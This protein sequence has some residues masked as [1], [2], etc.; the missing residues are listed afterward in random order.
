MKKLFVT[1]VMMMSAM[2][3]SAD[4]SA[5]GNR[6]GRGASGN[7]RTEK[8][9]TPS[10]PSVSGSND[11]FAT[12]PGNNNKPGNGTKPGGNKPGGNSG[13]NQGKPGKPGGNSGYKPGGGNKPGGNSGYRPD[14]PGGG[15]KP[16]GRPGGNSGYRPDKPG[17][18]HGYGHAPKPRPIRPGGYRPVVWERPYRPGL[19]PARPFYRP[20]PPP[21][22]RPTVQINLWTNILGVTVGM[23][24]NNAIDQLLYGGYAV[25]G[26]NRNE[27]FMSN[28]SM[29][30][31]NWPD[32][33]IYY[34][35][36]SLAGSRFYYSTIGYDTY[37]YDQ[38]YNYFVGYYGQP[39]AYNRTAEGM[40]VT[41][42]GRN[43]QFIT[44]DFGPQ[45]T[46]AGRR[47][48]TTI[49]IGL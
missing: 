39:V 4:M 29:Y 13:Y 44:L 21:A 38:M 30:N 26:Y 15:N 34:N 31:Y 28:V 14:K 46:D 3:I 11:K 49:S 1:I 20:V 5:Q 41:W 25:V 18:G 10:R 33:T 12:R 42:Y 43:N 45:L 36:N 7:V 40:S 8:K 35:G 22:Y 19:P 23:S 27:I 9:A 2:L 32:A 24:L 47:Y 37:R 6:P 17:K 16:G 48:F